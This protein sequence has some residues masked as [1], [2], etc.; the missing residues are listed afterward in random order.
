MH[1]MYFDTDP[2]LER[3]IQDL[4][5]HVE[6]MPDTKGKYKEKVSTKS[7]INVFVTVYPNSE[8]NHERCD[9]NLGWKLSYLNTCNKKVRNSSIIVCVTV[10]Q[11]NKQIVK[12]VIQS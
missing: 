6:R 11:K 12:N 7:S 1:V 2:C 9:T 5:S 4:T 3:L 8:Q 10:E